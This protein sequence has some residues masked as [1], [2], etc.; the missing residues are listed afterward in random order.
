[1]VSSLNIAWSGSLGRQV[2]Q[3]PKRPTIGTATAG[4]ASISVA[5]TPGALGTGTL[6]NYTADCGGITATG[7]AIAH[8]RERPDQRLQLYLQ[9]QD[10]HQRGHQRMVGQL[11][12]A[13][14]AAAPLVPVNVALVA[15][16]GVAS[17]QAPPPAMPS[18]PSTTTR[19]QGNWNVA[20]MMWSDSPG[21]FPDWVQINF[22]STKTINTVVV[23]SMQDAYAS[24]F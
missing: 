9:G 23:Y 13:T 14:P 17:Y 12:S 1:M 5:F 10:H 16:G 22:S 3:W 2:P 24:P 20:N 6:T 19:R 7:S 11:N 8:H 21:A 4:D 15:N 18:A